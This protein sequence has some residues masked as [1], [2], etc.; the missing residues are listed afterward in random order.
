M[1]RPAPPRCGAPAWASCPDAAGAHTRLPPG[2]PEGFL[3]A[4]ANLYR[5]YALTLQARL[6]GTEP[7]D[8]LDFPT[9]D[10]GVRGMAF[11]TACVA[12]FRERPQ[13]VPTGGHDMGRP[14]TLFT[15]QWADLPLEELAAKAAAWGF[16][17]LEL[18][19]WGDHFEVDKALADDGY[20]AAKREL[21]DRHGLK[22]F[23]ISNHLV[24]QCVCDFPIDARHQGI[25][26]P[27]IWGDGDPEGV[28]QRSAERMKETAPRRRRVRGGHGRRLH[29]LGDLVRG[30]R[31]SAGGRRHDRRR[32][33]G[34]RGPLEPDPGRL[35]CG[36]GA[37]RA[38]G[39][40]VGD[41]LRLLGA[42]NARWRRSTAVPRSGST[43][44]PATLVWQMVDPGAVR[45]GLRRPHLPRPR[46][47]I[48]A[49]T[50]NGR[51]GA[52]A[53][54]LPFG[55]LRRGWDFVSPGRGDVPF[56]R[57]FRALNAIGYQGPLSIEWEDSGMDREQ[58]APEALAFTRR[59]DLSASAIAFDAAFSQQD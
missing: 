13:V 29:R 56:E 36:R 33:P 7:P 31:V 37:L 1:G 25:L 30:R 43:S 18:A 17:G 42:R 46:Q 4:F 24:G 11:I 57:V 49:P 58:G 26:P 6:E 19:C 50:T 59:T 27:E 22:C 20:V 5:N 21:L 2:H 15:G 45:P 9:V 54:H 40:P 48:E 52:L 32:L 3:E 10:D 16:D 14:V 38:G 47:G 41:R 39:A 28:R 8:G 44:I 23:A 34:L 53:S 35:R 51:N 12:S 55:S